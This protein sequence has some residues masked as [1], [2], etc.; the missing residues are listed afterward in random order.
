MDWVRES[1]ITDPSRMITAQV[2]DIYGTVAIYGAAA[3]VGDH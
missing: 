2:L 3:Y 1:S